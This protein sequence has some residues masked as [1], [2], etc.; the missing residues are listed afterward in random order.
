MID[1]PR[2]RAPDLRRV[3]LGKITRVLAVD[4]AAEDALD[5]EAGGDPERNRVP[6]VERRDEDGDEGGYDDGPAPSPFVGKD[7]PQAIT[8]EHDDIGPEQG[9]SYHLRRP[10]EL[11]LQV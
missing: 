5:N 8:E 2:G 1:E 3:P 7:A 6:K 9:G 4:R 11:L 10:A